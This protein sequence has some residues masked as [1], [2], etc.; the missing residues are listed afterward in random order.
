MNGF[1]PTGNWQFGFKD[2][3][4]G[5]DAGTINSITLEICSQSLAVSDYE[6]EN[7]AMYPNPN[8][9]N[10][11]ISFESRSG[12]KINIA[13]HDMS[14]RKSSIR[15]TIITDCLLRTY[16]STMRKWSVFGF[17]HRRKQENRKEDCCSIA[18][19]NIK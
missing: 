9:G 11:T 10:F 2:N 12:N 17:N 1:N 16:N 8:K 15:T 3:V 14:G 18:N 13:V 19:H 5:A 7:F 4:A 6:F